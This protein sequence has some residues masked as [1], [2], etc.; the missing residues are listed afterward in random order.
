M[1]TEH[2]AVAVEDGVEIVARLDGPE[3]GAP[4]LI[5]HG[6]I[7]NGTSWQRHATSLAAAGYRVVRVDHRGHGASTKIGDESAYAFARLRDD[8]VAVMHVLG[9]NTFHL[10]GHSMGGYLSQMIAIDTPTVVRSLVLVGC[11]PMPGSPGSGWARRLRRVVGYHVGLHRVVRMGAPLLSRAMGS[12]RVKGDE[13]A[14]SAAKRRAGLKSFVASARQL[15]PAAFVSLGE[16]LQEHDDLRPFLGEIMVPTT[17]VIGENELAKIQE[18]A[19]AMAALIDGATLHVVP[20]AGH[21]VPMDQTEA[22][23]AIVHDHFDAAVSGR[24]APPTRA[25]SH[26]NTEST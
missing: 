16:Q 21:G 11:S 18:G 2:V 4:V 9:H 5:L 24:P 7:D 22:F 8:A 3:D 23:L 19:R 25:E 1:T 26:A 12:T 20:D 14:P 6:Y 17:I 13:G 15:D 10:M